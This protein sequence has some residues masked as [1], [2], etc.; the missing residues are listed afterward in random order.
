MCVWPLLSRRARL[1]N[2]S[3][4]A[5]TRYAPNWSP[6]RPVLRDF[7]KEPLPRLRYQGVVEAVKS[8]EEVV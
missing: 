4:V 2:L 1:T 8:L 3:F 6:T 5:A 7:V